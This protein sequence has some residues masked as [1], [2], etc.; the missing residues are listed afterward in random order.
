MNRKKSDGAAELRPPSPLRL[1]KRYTYSSEGKGPLKAAA[2]TVAA[3]CPAAED[4][5]EAG[6]R[7]YERGA[8]P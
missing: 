8:I 1:T 6:L 3:E 7:M 4:T 2:L 5:A